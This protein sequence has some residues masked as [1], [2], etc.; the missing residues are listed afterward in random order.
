MSTSSGETY[1]ND[2]AHVEQKNWHIVRQT[3]GYHRYD[4]A[5]ELELLNRIWALQ[6]LLTNHFGAQQKLVAKVRTGAK[7]SKTYDRPATP[8]QRVLAD[9]GTV[10]RG[11]KGPG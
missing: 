5:G 11:V 9:T 4:T 10:A 1:K 2:G 6:R 8:F 7:I 3:V